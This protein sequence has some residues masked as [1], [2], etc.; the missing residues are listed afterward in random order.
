MKAAGIA[1]KSPRR[2]RKTTDSNHSFPIADN[3]LDR[4]FAIKD[5]EAPNRV[6]AGDITYISTREGWLYLAIVIDLYSRK[7]I[8][9]SISSTMQRT[10]VLDA[11]QAAIKARRPCGPILFHSDRGS[12]YASTDFRAELKKHGFIASMSGKGE[13]WD[14]AV[15]ESFFGSLKSELDDPVWDSKEHAKSAIFEYIEIWYNL[16]RRHSTLGYVSPEQF[17]SQLPIAA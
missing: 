1:G 17:E 11:L 6:W 7:V 16:R 10:L 12:Q 14:N 9:W 13:C 15:V 3:R 8:G 4:K 2:F 5:V